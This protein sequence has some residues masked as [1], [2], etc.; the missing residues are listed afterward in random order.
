MKT[1]ILFAIQGEGR[2]HMTQAISL[3]QMLEENGFEICGVLVGTSARRK[4]P[5]FFHERFAGIP[6]VQMQSP[7]F[8]T[9]NNRGIHI[10]ATA[11]QNL[12][13]IRKYFK[14]VSLLRDKISE[15]QADLII[16]F[17][18]PIVGLYTSLTKASKRLPVIAIAHQ[19]LGAHADFR[20]P[21][22][23]ALDRFILE[24]YTAF[25]AKRADRLLGLSFYPPETFPE[26]KVFAVPPLLRREVKQQT[27]NDGGYFLC[28]LVNAG[29]RDDIENWHR[30]NPNVVMH[31]F[32]DM[33]SAKKQIEVQPNLFFH[34]LS[35]T[36]FLEKMAG[37]KGLISSAGFESICEAFWLGKP[38][39][40][41]P[42]E[43]HFEQFCNAFDASRAG[44]GIS[45]TRFAIEKFMD[46]L[47]SY[48]SRSEIFREWES[49]S[50]RIFLFHIREVL[51]GRRTEIPLKG[52][53]QTA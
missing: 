6:V 43:G 31:V 26:Q 45:D 38:V 23:H 50:E 9:K 19:Y 16:N 47:P 12:L 51:A 13:R 44:V 1:K 4:V 46:W 36:L 29:Y 3:K 17:Y 30:L 14:S 49:Q 7:N 18:E 34:Q 42:V 21:E 10:G 39:F 8:V 5:A 28:Y 11:W 22:G 41:V 27:T 15:W 40:M 20:F 33:S 32:T 37:C 25:T 2:G 48:Q 53:L 35:D 52:E 24:K